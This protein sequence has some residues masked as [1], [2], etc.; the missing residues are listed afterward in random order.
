VRLEYVLK[1]V[2][3]FGKVEGPDGEGVYYARVQNHR[4]RWREAVPGLVWGVGMS[5]WGGGDEGFF[6]GSYP[7]AQALRI[8]L[9]TTHESE[10]DPA[11]LVHAEYSLDR[12]L[13][14][15]V[16]VTIRP[17]RGAN[18]PGGVVGKSGAWYS[19]TPAPGGCFMLTERDGEGFA[20]ARDFARRESDTFLDWLQENRPGAFNGRG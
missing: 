4:L 14:E 1:N 19:L 12:R 5:V 10:A 17:R 6:H 8:C 18:D 9:G 20:L 16:R 15:V 3:R 7:L 13:R 11:G 2:K